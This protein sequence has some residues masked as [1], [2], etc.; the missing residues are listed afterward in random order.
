MN[1]KILTILLIILVASLVGAGFGVYYKY[2]KETNQNNNQNSENEKINF[3][4]TVF[5]TSVEIPGTG[6]SFK[7]PSKGFYG[8]GANVSNLEDEYH[9]YNMHILP[10][11]SCYGDV[12]CVT[13]DIFLNENDKNAQNINEFIDSYIAEPTK[14]IDKEYMR[15]GYNKSV[16]NKDYFIFSIAEDAPGVQAKTLY[17]DYVI[18]VGLVCKARNSEL[19]GKC[20]KELM[21]KILEN[22]DFE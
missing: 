1:K 16:N 22:I 2:F 8:L 12:G 11:D 10:Y 21:P 6:I 3:P 20:E 9:I 5:D 19:L 17:S 15:S 13:F 14:F 4:E 18:T 7:Y